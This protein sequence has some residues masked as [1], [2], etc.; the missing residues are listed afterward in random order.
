MTD[1][2]DAIDVVDVVIVGGGIAGLA[3]PSNCRSAAG[4]SSSRTRPRDGRRDYQ[5]TRRR[6][7]RRRRPRCAAHAETR[8]HRALRGARHRA[9]ASCRPSRRGSPTFNAADACMRCRRTPCSASRHASVRSFAR[10]CL[11]GPARCGWR[12]EMFVPRA[13]RRSSTNRS[14]RSCGAASAT[15]RRPISPSRCWPGSTPA[16]SIGSRFARSS[17]ASST[18]SASTAACCAPFAASVSRPRRPTASSD[19]SQ[20]G[21]SELV[22]ALTR[23]CQG[24]FGWIAT[25]RRPH[26]ARA[27]A[28]QVETEC[29]HSAGRAVIVTSP[30]YV[31]ADLLSERR[32]ELARL[33]REIPYASSGTSRSRFHATAVAHPLNGSGFVVP[34]VE[35]PASWPR[36]GCRRSGRTARRRDRC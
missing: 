25:V 29:W 10:D 22:R 31:T 21:L 14:A 35:R 30:A 24:R 28:R 20:D 5:R 32:R 8:R 34:R 4:R 9:I 2:V 16:T 23:A 1:A 36:R 18:P 15:K 3:P 17:R 33:C 11:R 27:T 12:A 19:R 26:E 6:L 7:R 13:A